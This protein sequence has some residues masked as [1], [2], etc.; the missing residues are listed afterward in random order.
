MAGALDGIRVVEVGEGKALAYA[1]KLLRD[2]GSEVIKVEPPGGD[3]LRGYG[4]FPDD[5]PNPEHS[6]LFIFMNGGKRGTRIDLK[7]GDGRERLASLLEGADVLLHSFRPA[8]AKRLGLEPDG[9]L[10]RHPRLIVSA[11]T[12]FGSSGPYA[13]WRGYAIQAQAG[14]TVAIR[15]GEPDREP[16]TSPLD[17]AEIQ[18]GAVHIA[19]ATVL[20]L[21]HRNRTGRGQFVDVGVMEAVATAVAANFIPEIVY[22]EMEPPVRSGRLFARGPWGIFAT[23]DGDFGVSTLVDRQWRAFLKYIGNPEWG[24]DPRFAQVSGQFRRSLS[25]EDRGELAEHL[26]RSIREYTTAEMWEFTRRARISFHPVHSVPQVVESD[27][28]EARGYFVPAPGPHPP[29][30]VP[31]A[32]YRMSTTPWQP[33]GPPPALDGEPASGWTSEPA[34]LPEPREAA[35]SLPLEGVRVID[36]GQVWAGPLLGRYLADY[37]ADVMLLDTESRPRALMG[38]LDPTSPLVWENTLRNRRSF[39]LDLRTPKGVELFKRLL[40]EADVMLD[41]FTP[42]TLPNLGLDYEQIA[43]ENPRLIIA[44]LS[45]AGRSGPW[46]DILSYGPTL[47]SGCTA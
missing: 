26:Q 10:E 15:N 7:T 5:E 22:G 30:T 37:G 1:G 44:Q 38:Q 31:G 47:T 45:A 21:V 11:V 34:T 9:L 40:G 35:G 14:S 19:T 8:E 42:R 16:I 46:E 18:H 13:D 43:A 32:P 23:R 17:Q 4:P 20:A 41:N 36:L 25:E 6:G 27:H 33:P 3:A 12:T 2:L 29:L 39:Q 28:M 24:D